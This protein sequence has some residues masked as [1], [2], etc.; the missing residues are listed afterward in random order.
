MGA[1]GAALRGQPDALGPM[2]GGQPG[3]PGVALGSKPRALG[4]V[5]CGGNQEHHVFSILVCICLDS[6][7]SKTY[8]CSY[9]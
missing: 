8:A 2:L 3:A 1:H 4:A 7:A 6:K 5:L 9:F